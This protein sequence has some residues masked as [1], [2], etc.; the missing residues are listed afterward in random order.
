MGMRSKD[1]KELTREELA[2]KF[3][4]ALESGDA[5]AVAQAFADMAENIQQEVLEKAKDAAAVEQ[6][7]AAALAA[8]G[9]RQLTSE[10]ESIMK[11]LSMP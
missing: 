5:A 11:R 6:M 10:E 3:N 7:D 9:L 2:Q 1:L 8:R 4:N